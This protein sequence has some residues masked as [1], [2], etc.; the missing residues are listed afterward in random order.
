MDIFF[1]QTVHAT[2]I[3]EKSQ[4][5]ITVRYIKKTGKYYMKYNIYF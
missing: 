1:L 4:S 3:V 2:D 5:A